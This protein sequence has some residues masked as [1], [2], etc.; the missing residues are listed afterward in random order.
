M[1]RRLRFLD[2]EVITTY[3]CGKAQNSPPGGALKARTRRTYEIGISAVLR[4]GPGVH[5]A[6]VGQCASGVALLG[7]EAHTTANGF[8]SS[9]GTYVAVYRRRAAN[10]Q[11]WRR[12][13]WGS[14]M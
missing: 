13:A 10:C 14:K 8:S 7:S 5:G 2:S 6:E 12:P 1:S 9:C 11:G 4:H 3:P